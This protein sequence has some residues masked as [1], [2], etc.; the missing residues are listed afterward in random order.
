MGLFDVQRGCVPRGR[1]NSALTPFSRAAQHFNN[2]AYAHENVT[3]NLLILFTSTGQLGQHCA[4]CESNSPLLSASPPHVSHLARLR[5]ASE[6]ASW[7]AALDK[8]ALSFLDEAAHTFRACAGK[9]VLG[10]TSLPSQATAKEKTRRQFLLRL[11]RRRL[12]LSE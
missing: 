4:A 12:R 2:A 5:R 1:F 11:W 3:S 8:Y 10:D 6:A 9:R 7:S